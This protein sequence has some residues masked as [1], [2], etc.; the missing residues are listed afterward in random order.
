MQEWLTKWVPTFPTLRRLETFARFSRILST[1][2]NR[3]FDSGISSLTSRLS[4]MEQEG[5]GV[6]PA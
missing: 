4:Q 5:S 3:D 6:I 1:K 2:A